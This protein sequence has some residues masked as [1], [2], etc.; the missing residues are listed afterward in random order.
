MIK[1]T[2]IAIICLILLLFAMEGLQ[3]IKNRNLQTQI[4]ELRII[5]NQKNLPALIL[6]KNDFNVR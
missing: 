4:D 3:I 5:V 6:D 1:N 2:E